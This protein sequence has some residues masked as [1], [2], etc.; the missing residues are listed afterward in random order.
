MKLNDTKTNI[1]IMTQRSFQDSTI[2]H[3]IFIGKGYE[4][5]IKSNCYWNSDDIP[6]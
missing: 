5:E 2:T 3:R 1:I 4:A 6:L